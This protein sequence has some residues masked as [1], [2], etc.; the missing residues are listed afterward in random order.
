MG[1]VPTIEFIR[2]AERGGLIHS[3]GRWVLEQALVQQ[4]EWI[5]RGF[6]PVRLA[7]NVSAVQLSEGDWAASVKEVLERTGGDP[8]R[9]EL[10]ITET[11]LLQD[12]SVVLAAFRELGEMGVGLVLDDFGTGY[13]QLSYLHRYPI[14]R[15]KIDRSFIASIDDT[16]TGAAVTQAILAMARSL[17]LQTIGEGVETEDQATFLIQNGCD[18]IQGYL[19]SHALPPEEFERFLVSC[20]GAHDGGASRSP[21]R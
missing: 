4:Q 17:G 2:L 8:T 15:I 5:Q 3:I 10:E 13:S 18:E 21:V 11:A 12:S 14:H 9:L 6:E 19:V 16:P 1:P 20:K 7:V